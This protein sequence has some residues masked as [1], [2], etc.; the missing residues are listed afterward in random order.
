MTKRIE[1]YARI[2]TFLGEKII[3]G[4]SYIIIIDYITLAPPSRMVS[5]PDCMSCIQSGNKTN[6]L[7]RVSACSIELLLNP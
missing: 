1:N 5:C 7:I 6:E 4:I 3:I 2:I